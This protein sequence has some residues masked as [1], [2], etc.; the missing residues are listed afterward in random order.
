MPKVFACGISWGG[1]NLSYFSIFK[2]KNV[3]I[4]GSYNKG[5]E[6]FSKLEL[7]DFIAAKDG[8]KIIA[9][10]K[11]NSE[12]KEFVTWHDYASEDEAKKFGFNLDDEIHAV[13][14]KYWHILDKYIEYQTQAG[15][16]F[17]HKENII[18]NIINI[19]NNRLE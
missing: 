6:N 16:F 2:E 3:A 5:I 7:E 14:I 10:G 18:N 8:H 12:V 13:S 9:I 17:I 1:H 19:Y 4:L 11:V 15:G